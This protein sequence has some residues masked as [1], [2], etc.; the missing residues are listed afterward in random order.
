MQ[1]HTPCYTSTCTTYIADY[2][3]CGRTPLYRDPPGPDDKNP[4]GRVPGLPNGAQIREASRQEGAGR[5]FCATG[6]SNSGSRRL[7]DHP[8]L[9]ACFQKLTPQVISPHQA[10]PGSVGYD[11]YTPI[12]FIIQP[13]TQMTVFTDIALTPPEGCY[14]QLMSKSGLTVQHQL[15]VKAGVIDPD[16]TGNIGV[17]LRNNSDKVIQRTIGEPIA[18]L[19]FIKI[20]TPVLVQVSGLV[21]TQRSHYGFGAHSAHPKANL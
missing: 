5:L 21:Q 1:A 13:N 2:R 9:K 11:L 20:A 14:A 15:D 7:P 16:F 10:T 12:N 18:Q 8:V 3:G 17:V 4:E 6:V 19:L